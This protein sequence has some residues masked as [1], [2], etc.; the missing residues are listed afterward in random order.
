MKIIIGVEFDIDEDE[1]PVVLWQIETVAYRLN[2]EQVMLYQ[3]SGGDCLRIRQQ[4]FAHGAFQ[5][6]MREEEDGEERD[7]YR[8]QIF[9]HGAFQT[10]MREEEDGEERD[11]YA[12]QHAG[13]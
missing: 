11:D 5:T 13:S 8:Q 4:I 7:D 12:N 2:C 3:D 1:I 9:A 10:V 6:V